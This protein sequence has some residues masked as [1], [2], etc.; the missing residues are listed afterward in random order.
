MGTDKRIMIRLN[1]ACRR[2]PKN[3]IRVRLP[4]TTEDPGTPS[5]GGTLRPAAAA[6]ARNS[7]PCQQAA[8]ARRSSEAQ[9]AAST[10]GKAG[11]CNSSHMVQTPARPGANTPARRCR[12]VPNIPPP[13]T[14]AATRRTG[15]VRTDADNTGADS[16]LGTAARRHSP[17]PPGSTR[18]Q[19]RVSGRA[20]AQHGTGLCPG[21]VVARGTALRMAGTCSRRGA[22]TV[23]GPAAGCGCTAAA[24]VVAAAAWS[25]W[26]AHTADG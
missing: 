15:H 14:Q 12:R 6:E 8:P 19:L 21:F 11:V 23:A 22:R 26:S 3:D 25:G 20:A 18:T 2:H 16:T 10:A 17:S 7:T 1:S 9:T 5:R 13:R 24:A 4:M